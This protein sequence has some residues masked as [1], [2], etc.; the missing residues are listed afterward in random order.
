MVMARCAVSNG[1]YLG[2]ENCQSHADPDLLEPIY[3]GSSIFAEALGQLSADAA[4]P[5]GT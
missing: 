5:P 1:F 4:N 3:I 2:L